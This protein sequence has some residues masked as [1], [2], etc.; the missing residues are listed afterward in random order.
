MAINLVFSLVNSC[1]RTFDF[2]GN[3]IN[4]SRGDLGVIC[5]TYAHEAARC[6]LLFEQYRKDVSDEF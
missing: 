5:V 3:E 6:S 4:I 1:V 2:V